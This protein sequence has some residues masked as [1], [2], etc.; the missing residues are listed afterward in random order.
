[1]NSTKPGYVVPTTAL[2]AD[3][4]RNVNFGDVLNG[5][6]RTGSAAIKGV[7]TG[8]YSLPSQGGI[9]Q[10]LSDRFTT[11]PTADEVAVLNGAPNSLRAIEIRRKYGIPGQSVIGAFQ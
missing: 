9:G 8:D 2:M 6:D 7:V 11:A 3:G 1:M 4:A 5:V 10:L